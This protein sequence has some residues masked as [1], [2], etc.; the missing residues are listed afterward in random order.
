MKIENII[1]VGL[2]AVCD[3]I[4]LCPAPRVGEQRK[5]GNRE[6]QNLEPAEGRSVRPLAPS[7]LP[8]SPSHLRQNRGKLLSIDYASLPVTQ[9]R[10]GACFFRHLTSRKELDWRRTFQHHRLAS[11]A[12]DQHHPK[13]SREPSLGEARLRG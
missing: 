1:T 12:H 2:P 9:P 13:G 6:R 7:V 3:S 5:K 11:E 8:L 4:S 10:S